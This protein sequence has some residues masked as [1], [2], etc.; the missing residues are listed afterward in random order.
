[1]ILL[2]GQPH[3]LYFLKW[4]AVCQLPA[5]PEISENHAS[6]RIEALYG[7]E[8]EEVRFGQNDSVIGRIEG[9][10]EPFATGG[11]PDLKTMTGVAPLSHATTR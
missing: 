2:T 8:S 1:M 4:Q 3:R 9:C 10:P 7:S 5:R 6:I 11:G